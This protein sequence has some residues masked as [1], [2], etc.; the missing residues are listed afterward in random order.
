MNKYQFTPRMIHCAEC[1]VET[2]ATHNRSKF[3]PECSA[4]RNME[5]IKKSNERQRKEREKNMVEPDE[6]I[7]YCDSPEKIQMCLNCKKK[8]CTNCLC[9]GTPM[10]TKRK[11]QVY[12]GDIRE[13]LIE[14]IQKGLTVSAMAR[15]FVCADSSI[16]RWVRRLQEEGAV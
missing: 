7:H 15:K 3:C 6:P 8:E 2:L 14:C 4:R 11:P 5:S 13:E 9:F 16:R 10:A 12:L 1:G